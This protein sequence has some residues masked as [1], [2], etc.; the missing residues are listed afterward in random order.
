MTAEPVNEADA[1][2]ILDFEE[3]F[4]ARQEPMVRLATLM[5]GSRSR[6][7]ELVQDAFARVY[8][9]W[10]SVRHPST[11]LRTAVVNGCRNELRRDRLWRRVAGRVHDSD[12]VHDEHDHLFDALDLLPSRRKAAV[13]LRYYEGLSEAEIAETL[14]CRPGTVKSLLHRAM[15]QL[16]QEIER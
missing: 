8:L 2:T 1:V 6:A 16:R 12:A 5:V 13:V 4:A 3:L 7:E 10:S 15:E 9:K 14:G 11:Y